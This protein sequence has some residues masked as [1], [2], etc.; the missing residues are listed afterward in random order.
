MAYLKILGVD[1]GA[2]RT[3]LAKSDDL[4]MFSV[5]LGNIKSYNVEKAAQDVAAKANEINADIVVVGKPINMDGSCGE[6]AQNAIKFGEMI[7]QYTNAKIDYFD[8]RLTTV[9]AHQILGDSGIKAKNRK[10][11]VDSLSAEI[12][13][14]GYMDMIKNKNNNI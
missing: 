8:E 12:I 9:M 13:L 11:V 2:A 1:F 5:G 4:F 3:G 10:N 6:K 14:Q 7:S